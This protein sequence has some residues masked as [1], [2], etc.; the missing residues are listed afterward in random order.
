M[1]SMTRPDRRPLPDKSIEE[2]ARLVEESSLGTAGARQL[3][4]RAAPATTARIRVRAYIASNDVGRAWWQAN[5][6]SPDALRRKARELAIC[7][8]LEISDVLTRL[9]AGQESNTH[10]VSAAADTPGHAGHYGPS[11]RMQPVQAEQEVAAS[12]RTFEAF[13]HREIDPLSRILCGR[14]NLPDSLGRELIGHAMVKAFDDWEHLA[15]SSNPAEWVLGYALQLY[16][17]RRLPDEDGSWAPSEAA[18]S[19]S[20]L[21]TSKQSS[22]VQCTDVRV[23]GAL[24]AA[25]SLVPLTATNA[26]YTADLAVTSLYSTHYGSLVHLAALLVRDTDTA[27]EIVQ[28]SFVAMHGAWRRLEDAEKA[29]SYLRQSVVNRARSVLRHRMVVDRNRPKPSAD[30]PSAEHSAIVLLE[31]SAVV[32]AL[33][34]LPDRQREALVLRYYGDLSEA[35][36][37]TAMGISRGAVKSHTARAMSALRTV[38]EQES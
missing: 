33:R 23:T 11:G 18:S 16:R 25:A 13:Y 21:V 29:L 36:I 15:E 4:D 28:D 20:A 10:A 7:G 3:R 26:E 6:H 14:A 8:N 34:A 1:T 38:L 24:A 17:K 5:Q 9:A 12:W 35:Q 27:E 2:V 37:A 30:M 31:R 22:V 32:A 19:G